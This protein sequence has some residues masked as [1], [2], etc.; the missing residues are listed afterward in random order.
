M[1]R[2]THNRNAYIQTKSGQI[3]GLYDNH[4]VQQ[5]IITHSI[6]RLICKRMAIKSKPDKSQ[7]K[8]HA[9]SRTCG[10]GPKPIVQ[11]LSSSCTSIKESKLYANK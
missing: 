8:Q 1:L 5:I 3:F 9:S 7:F 4:I 2:R 10:R 11:D 6:I